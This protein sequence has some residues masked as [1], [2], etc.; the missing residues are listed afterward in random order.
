MDGVP[1]SLLHVLAVTSA[2][3]GGLTFA[4]MLAIRYGWRRGKPLQEP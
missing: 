3:I 1:A 2:V 4:V